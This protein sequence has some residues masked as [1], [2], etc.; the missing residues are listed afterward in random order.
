[1]GHVKMFTAQEIYDIIPIR[2]DYN[3]GEVT[4]NGY[5]MDKWVKGMQ[6]DFA[7]WLKKNKSAHFI[8][9][10]STPEYFDLDENDVLVVDEEEI[11]FEVDGPSDYFGYLI[12]N[13]D[14]YI[15]DVITGF[16]SGDRFNLVISKV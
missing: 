2:I 12:V 1:M 4:D 5:D 3:K 7:E 9:S 10:T 14:I 6:E 16:G 15:R 11:D 13:S 8:I